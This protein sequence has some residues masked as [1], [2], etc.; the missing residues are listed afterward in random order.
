MYKVRLG[1][2]V[3]MAAIE[4]IEFEVVKQ[5][6]DGSFEIEAVLDANQV[7]KYENIA[8]EMLKVSTRP[9]KNK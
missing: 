8:K 6:V 5:N 7:L 3:T 4:N 1:A 2:K 9:Q